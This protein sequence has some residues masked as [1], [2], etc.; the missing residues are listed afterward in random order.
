FDPLLAVEAEALLA[1]AEATTATVIE[2]I[3]RRED[4]YR[5]EPL[6]RSIAGGPDGTEDDNWT[7]YGYRYLNRTH[8]AYYYTRI[9]GL[10]AAALAGGDDI[11]EIPDTVIGPGETLAVNLVS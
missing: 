11:V 3:R 9:D 6:S 7:V 10:A 1:D 4:G 8:H 2:I 5:Y